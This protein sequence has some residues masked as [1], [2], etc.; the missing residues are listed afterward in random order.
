MNIYNFIYL[1]SDVGNALMTRSEIISQVLYTDLMLGTNIKMV[2]V[3]MIL[4]VLVAYVT[5]WWLFASWYC[6]WRRCTAYSSL[7]C[8]LFRLVFCGIGRIFAFFLTCF[9][10]AYAC[11]SYH[12]LLQ[13]MVCSCCMILYKDKTW[14]FSWTKIVLLFTSPVDIHRLCCIMCFLVCGNITESFWEK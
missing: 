10:F 9:V 3:H 14:F 5:V 2:I 6:C 7:C 11:E 13:R 4:E 1:I 12:R 8:S